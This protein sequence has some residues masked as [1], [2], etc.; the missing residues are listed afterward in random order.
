MFG[1]IC[2]NL[3][4]VD[5]MSQLAAASLEEPNAADRFIVVELMICLVR[6][7]AAVML[8]SVCQ[9]LS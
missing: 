9:L 4:W 8:A 2:L 7:P 5:I 6:T 3:I 1:S